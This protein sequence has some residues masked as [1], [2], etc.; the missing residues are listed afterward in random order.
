MKVTLNH[1]PT[2][3]S[4]PLMDFDPSNP[5]H[6]PKTNGIYV[7]GLRLMVDKEYKFV[8]IVVGEGNLFSRLFKDHYLK[9]FKNPFSNLMCS[10]SLAIGDKKELWNF[11]NFICSRSV[12]KNVYNQMAIYDSTQSALRYQLGPK[13]NELIYFQDFRFYEHL[14]APP[15]T[16]KKD[17]NV[18]ETVNELKNGLNG[19]L[20]ME[21]IWKIEATLTNFKSHFYFVYADLNDDEHVNINI[22]DQIATSNKTMKLTERIELAT[23]IALQKISINTSAKAVGEIVKMEIDL[24]LIQNELVNVGGHDYGF[25][26]YSKQVK[27]EVK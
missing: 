5:E 7:Y 27:I 26:D 20:A 16:C 15:A 22:D 23:K 2:G 17:L 3:T 19:N 18:V 12:V 21:Y 8:P 24:S 13:I 9:K 11:S 4:N 25:P 1:P 6:Y 10:T 14:I